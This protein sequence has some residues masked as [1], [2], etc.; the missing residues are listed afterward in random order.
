MSAQWAVCR[1]HALDVADR[2]DQDRNPAT[3][4]LQAGDLQKRERMRLAIS[5][6]ERGS[7]SV[8]MGA[9]VAFQAA[10]EASLS[11]KTPRE[12]RTRAKRLGT[13][14]LDAMNPELH[15]PTYLKP[16]ENEEDEACGV[17]QAGVKLVC[18]DGARAGCGDGHRQIENLGQ[19]LEDV[20]CNGETGS[21]GEDKDRWK[22]LKHASSSHTFTTHFNTQFTTQF[23][24]HFRAKTRGRQVHI[25][26]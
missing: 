26:V 1:Q 4:A 12:P 2:R 5:V 10:C 6:P 24:T 19:I 13:G 8:G 11:K 16:Q 3:L 7:D 9:V 17:Q 25:G 21:S 14:S 15:L 18:A 23:T 22:D 20:F